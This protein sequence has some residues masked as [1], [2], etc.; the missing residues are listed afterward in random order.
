MKLIRVT[1][2]AIGAALAGVLS[3]MVIDMLG[4]AGYWPS[5]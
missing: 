5:W 1:A 2:I 3:L 4:W